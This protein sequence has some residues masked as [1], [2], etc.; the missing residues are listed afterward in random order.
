MAAVSTT[1]AK[2]FVGGRPWPAPGFGSTNFP[3]RERVN[4]A[5]VATEGHPDKNS[6]ME[7]KVAV[8]V[9]SINQPSQALQLVAEGCRRLGYDFIVIGDEASP[10]EF[11]LDGCRFYSLEEQAKLGFRFAELCPTRHYAR[12]NIGYLI[13][14]RRGAELILELDD[15]CIPNAN[16]WHDRER[17][18]HVPINSGDGWVNIFRY[19]SEVKIWPRGLPLDEINHPVRDFETLPY[20]EVDC[21]IQ[22][23]LTDG[24]PDVD[25]IYRLTSE[26]PQTFRSDRRLALKK[27]SWSPFNTQNTAWWAGA[28]PLL[29][30]PASCQFRVTDIWRSYV[31]QRIAWTNDWGVLFHEPT[32]T[33]QRNP[34]D[35]MADFVSELPAYL[36]G[37]AICARLGELQLKVGL[38]HL[39]DNLRA[40]YTELI[41]MDAVEKSELA[42]LEAWLEDIQRLVQD[43]GAKRV[44]DYRTGRGSDRSQG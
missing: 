37:K 42:L 38:E 2:A 17:I 32:N 26:L 40:C 29:Y 25:A 7:N 10:A 35:L 9:T 12:K 41:E 27:G 23:G 4:A 28:F 31:A 22:H 43:T 3:V 39:P 19:F 44:E 1:P 6:S 24:N 21:P 5:R 20:E 16:F 18:Q 34:H 30:L 14:I 8:V 33:Q 13:A 11:P 36:H 15:D